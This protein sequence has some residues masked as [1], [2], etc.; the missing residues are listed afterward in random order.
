MERQEQGVRQ[1]GSEA[2]STL[3][4]TL[5]GRVQQAIQE[6]GLVHA[7]DFC[8]VRAQPLTAEVDQQLGSLDIKRTTFQY[9]NPRNAPDALEVEALQYFEQA[10]AESGELPSDYVQFV[11]ANEFRYYKPLVVQEGC[12][13]CHGDPASFSPELREVLNERYP[14]DNAVGYE[15]GDFRGVV[16]VSVPTTQVR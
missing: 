7:L 11:H 14:N 1:I 4:S 3:A 8:S 10:M 2:A 16:R 9:R 12:L 5:F 6:G 13:N 15:Q